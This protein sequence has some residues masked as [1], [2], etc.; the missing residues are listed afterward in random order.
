MSRKNVL[1]PYHLVTDGN[2]SGN[3]TSDATTITYT[4]NIAFQVIFAGA[5]VGTFYVDGTLNGT[6]WDALEFET[7]P[8]AAGV[9]ASFLININQCPYYKL[10][11]RYVRTSGTGTLQVY[12]MTKTVGA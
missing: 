12:T 8:T 6:T 11:V 2:M 4:D 10:R 1:T 7:D 9:D 3:I 5:P